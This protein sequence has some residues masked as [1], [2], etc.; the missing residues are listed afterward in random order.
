MI[1]AHL[2][3]R[4]AEDGV[5]REGERGLCTSSVRFSCLHDHIYAHSGFPTSQVDSVFFG[6]DTYRFVSFVE[7][8]LEK[9]PLQLGSR[10][11]DIGCGAGPG[12][13]AALLHGHDSIDAVL[14]DINPQALQFSRANAELAGVSQ[15]CATTLSDLFASV[16]GTF[17]LIISNPPYLVDAAQRSYRHG[18]GD[19]GEGLAQRILEQSLSRLNP[20]GRV[21]LY[22]GSA[23]LKG[24]DPF[25]EWAQDLSTRAGYSFKRRE[26]DPDVFGEEL[27]RGEYRYID[28]IA[29]I[30]L[31]VQRPHAEVATTVASHPQ[32]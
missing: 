2:R 31:S 16:E 12:G 6:P 15:R 25:A 18:G 11:L 28:R 8:E 32:T 19:F 4:L 26:I 13:I 24:V 10:V 27:E 22:T 3:S 17:D 5:I 1:P 14:S 23:V 7:H 9:N 29:A 30:G 20:G 21:L